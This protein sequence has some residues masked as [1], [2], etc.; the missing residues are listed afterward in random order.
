MHTTQRLTLLI[1]ILSMFFINFCFAQQ[2]KIDSLEQ[3]V[4]DPTLPDTTKIFAMVK[5]GGAYSTSGI[6]RDLALSYRKKAA[7]LAREQRDSKFGA[8][9][10]AKLSHQYTV[11]D[12][13]TR[14]YETLD[15]CLYF[16]DKTTDQD[17]RTEVLLSLP[18]TKYVLSDNNGVL[19]MLLEAYE[20]NKDDQTGTKL[21]R[22]YHALSI[23]YFSFDLIKAKEYAYLC[24]K[25]AQI[26]GVLDQLST[27]WTILGA[28]LLE[29][30]ERS[31]E[32]L[33]DSAM[34]ACKQVI[35]LYEKAPDEVQYS[36]YMVALSNLGTIFYGMRKSDTDAFIYPDSILYYSNKVRDIA[37]EKG[38]ADFMDI[39]TMIAD[40]LYSQN[41]VAEAEHAFLEALNI[42]ENKNGFYRHK[43]FINGYA[44]SFYKDRNNYKKA[45]VHKEKQMEYLKEI[46]KKA[47][48]K[49][50]LITEAKYQVQ[51]KDNELKLSQQK[52][53]QQKQLL[54]GSFIG[55]ILLL[56]FLLT[57]YRNRLRNTKQKAILVEK[58]NEEIRLN[59][60]VKEKELQKSELDK[61]NL[62]L[63]KELE[64]E[65]AERRALEIK[66]LQTELVAGISQ[67]DQKNEMIEKIKEKTD[68]R[69][70]KALLLSDKVA[71]KSYEGFYELFE[72]IHPLFYEKLQEKAEQR[73][74]TL[75]LR[76]CT[77]I[78]MSFSSKEIANIMHVDPNTVRTTK[79]R[80]KLKLNLSKEEDIS[81]YLEDLKKSL[82]I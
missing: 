12:S 32:I 53:K 76:Y 61:K 8:I 42:L 17:I 67:L 10:Y 38:D 65:K 80:L 63:E 50:G 74:T 2:N 56:L 62:E 75:D 41:K 47:Y 71:G 40:V 81:T 36:N 77:Y 46:H 72:K 44:Y 54:V 45:L 7:I 58:E 78:L 18:L 60:L 24:L 43:E 35:H 68:D 1:G 14:A 13:I 37:I 64:K 26:S 39:A 33:R 31:D 70:I 3:I 82:E 6:N 29:S 20:L 11:L 51:K 48:I 22:V 79:Y 49:E 28:I 34:Y 9:A 66:R 59:A 4:N 15:S 21:T 16:L 5:L 23:Y 19:D 55:A 73:L 69:N 30:S 27:A 57:F 25:E 52:T